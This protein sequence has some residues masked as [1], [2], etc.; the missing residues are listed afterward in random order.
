MPER[1]REKRKRRRTRTR[2][3]AWICAAGK[4]KPTACVLWDQSD[5]GARVAA[6]HAS[7]LPDVFTLI[8][9][10][11][12]TPRLCRIA[13]RK[14]S[15]F[16]VQFVES[17]EEADALAAAKSRNAQPAGPA[18]LPLDLNGIKLPAD[19]RYLATSHDSPAQGGLSVSMVAA[20]LLVVL[21]ALTIVFY[22]AGQE[23]G[24][25]TAWAD[26]VCRQAGNMCRHPEFS[27]GAS[28][29]MALIYFAARGMEF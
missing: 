26:G 28:V 17:V 16:G 24:M 13:W 29:L 25:G 5:K 22:F 14:G 6:A 20:G 27:G 11:Q 9:D 12:A 4:S 23:T 19:P 15:Q 21:A 18:R 7:K 10:K 3:A 8:I 1:A 2:Q